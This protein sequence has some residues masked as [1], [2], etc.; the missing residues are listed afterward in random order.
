MSE[1]EKQNRRQI[2]KAREELVSQL[3]LSQIQK[4]NEKGWREAKIAHANVKK[5]GI[6]RETGEPALYRLGTRDKQ[7]IVMDFL[8]NVAVDPFIRQNIVEWIANNTGDYV[9]LLVSSMA[10]DINVNVDV[11]QHGVMLVPSRERDMGDWF[12]RQKELKEAAQPFSMEDVNWKT[13]PMVI[14]VE[15][16]D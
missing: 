6:D 3:D 15:S 14:E 12:E 16:V 11:T 5:C 2:K 10:K 9:K 7:K 13:E 8:L 1:E 4:I